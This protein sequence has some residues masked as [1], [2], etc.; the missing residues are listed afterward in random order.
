M[1]N[2]Q[3][4]SRYTDAY[5]VAR[6]VNRI[7]QTIKKVGLIGGVVIFVFSVIVPVLLAGRN[8]RF[9]RYASSNSEFV[10]FARNG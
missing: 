10:R 2:D 4:E 5:L 7:G 6:T 3:I 1:T 8:A 9:S